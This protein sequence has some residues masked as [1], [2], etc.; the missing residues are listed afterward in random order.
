MNITQ[1]E[2]NFIYQLGKEAGMSKSVEHEGWMFE[3][4]KYENQSMMEFIRFVKMHYPEAM[5]E[6]EAVEK[7]KES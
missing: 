3:N 1:E 6:F 5:A 7:I 4:M 2:L